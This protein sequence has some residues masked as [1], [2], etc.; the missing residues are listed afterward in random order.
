MQNISFTPP[1]RRVASDTTFHRASFNNQIS[2]LDKTQKEQL[3]NICDTL[4]VQTVLN[5]P[6]NSIETIL[7]SLQLIDA[8][9]S[10]RDARELVTICN[11][12][13]NNDDQ[14][15][16]YTL[17]V[18][19]CFTRMR[20]SS[21]AIQNVSDVDSYSSDETPLQQISSF[22][23][24]NLQNA[25]LRGAALDGIDLSGANLT[26]ANLTGAN[27][28]GANLTDANLTG[29]NLTSASA[30][31]ADFTGIIL[32]GANLTQAKFP[33]VQFKD[34]DLSGCN[35]T[36]ANLQS[37]VLDNCLVNNIVL[38]DTILRGAKLIRLTLHDIDMRNC[39]MAGIILTDITLNNCNLEKANMNNC[40]FTGSSYEEKTWVI[41][42]NLKEAELD[43]IV[44]EHVVFDTVDISNS[45][46][47]IREYNHDVSITGVNFTETGMSWEYLNYIANEGRVKSDVDT[48]TFNV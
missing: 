9:F 6:Q 2:T 22:T 36:A 7:Q 34:A 41:N 35:L 20:G 10:L 39:N 40:Q 3:G 38:K 31:G 21:N 48:C 43:S 33:Y 19:E 45:K 44:L 15:S 32:R 42:C 11:A 12:I 37:S 27:L 29:A 28:T 17:D 5:L 13:I 26:G 14:L 47:H 4:Y 46:L 24:F 1:I 30:F 18:L 23:G 8:S 16:K 25:D